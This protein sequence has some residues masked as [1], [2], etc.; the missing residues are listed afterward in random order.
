MGGVRREAG[1]LDAVGRGKGQINHWAGHD[2]VV[3]ADAGGVVASDADGT[4][5]VNLVVDLVEAAQVDVRVVINDGDVLVRELRFQ[6]G[7]TVGRAL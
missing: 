5:V 1:H 6:P 3:C 2:K 4:R 7:G